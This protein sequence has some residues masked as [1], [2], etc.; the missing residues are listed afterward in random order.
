MPNKHIEYQKVGEEQ[1]ADKQL[2]NQSSAK[3]LETSNDPQQ[4]AI[5]SLLRTA[6]VSV[7][8]KLATVKAA[9]YVDKDRF[10]NAFRR[11]MAGSKT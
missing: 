8:E 5:R 2:E 3:K 10:Q 9:Q 1:H 11:L 7:D 6:P 4:L